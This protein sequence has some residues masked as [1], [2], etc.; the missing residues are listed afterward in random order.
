SVCM[1]LT[2]ELIARPMATFFVGY[3][4]DLLELTV[5]GFRLY[6]F[7]FLFAGMGI[8]GSSFFTALNNGIVSAVI[9]ALRTLGFQVLAILL[10]PVFWGTDGIWISEVFAEAM[11]VV[12]V[13]I[14]LV[15]FRKRYRYW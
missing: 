9:S 7:M 6:S 14:C 3:D 1:F 2:S 15:L 5:R 8:F 10:F 4:T 13:V 11:T 12:M